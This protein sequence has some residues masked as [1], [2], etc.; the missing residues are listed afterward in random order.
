VRE[1]LP[2]GRFVVL[3]ESFSGPIAIELAANMLERAAGLVLAAS[4]A[5]NP[6][7][8]GAGLAR[9]WLSL[10][11]PR[12]QWAM[13]GVLMGRSATPELKR[14]LGETLATIPANV[15]SFRV[16]E[17]T[18]V[19]KR[20]SLGRVACPILYLKGKEDWLLGEAPMH[21]I[22]QTAKLCDV[23]EIDGPHM[24]LATHSAEA[25]DAIEA[26]CATLP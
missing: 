16:R 8:F 24:L 7:P 2:P 11:L 4:F 9:A 13:A 1:Q 3:G 14:A 5:R 26:F 6:L 19:D 12:P 10:R 25:A 20:A 15:V 21:E 18:R 17:A 22:M 23:R